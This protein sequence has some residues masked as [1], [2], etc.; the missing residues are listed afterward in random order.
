[1]WPKPSSGCAVLL[2]AGCLAL[3]ELAMGQ[4]PYSNTSAGRPLG[5]EDAVSIE[6]QALDLHVSRAGGTFAA[7][8]DRWSLAP[9][10]AWG[11]LPRTQ[12][13]LM[14]PLSIGRP[15][16]GVD[17]AVEAS[18]LH[19]LNVESAGMPA[20]ALRGT[21]LVP[22]VDGEET[23]A[24]P[25]LKAIVTRTFK[26][27]RLHF[28]HQHTFGEGPGFEASAQVQ[29]LTRWNTGFA[30]DRALPL[31]GLLIGA[32]VYASR[33]LPRGAP[34]TWNAGLGARYQ[35]TMYTTVEAGA[36]TQFVEDRAWAFSVGF[37]RR[38]GIMRLLPGLGRWGRN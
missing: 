25:S 31:K 11:L 27:G 20:V 33:A 34:V 6:R 3:P 26:W 7:A 22:L 28:N 9:G 21:M 38:T 30:A 8:E 18:V 36:V 1:M 14:I 29:S 2:A 24:H 19:A 17:A 23:K 32:E 4:T 10:L 12:V 35:I 15:G 5:I 13:D 16:D 37:S